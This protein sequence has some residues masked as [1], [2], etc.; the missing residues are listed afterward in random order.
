MMVVPC[1]VFFLVFAYIPMT[2][3]IVAF[4]NYSFTKG[5]FRSPWASNYGFKYFIDFFGYYDCG[6]IIRNTF[7]SGFFKAILPFP[8]PILFALL[9]NEVGGNKFKRTVQTISYLP[10]FIS[11]VIVSVMLFRILAPEDGIVNQ[12]IGAAGGRTDTFFMMED[13]YF[14]PILFLSLLWKNIGWSS[15][16]Y[17]AAISGIDPELYEAAKI[18]GAKKLRQIWHITLAGLKPTMGILFILAL[19]GIVS[20]GFEQNF[21]LRTPGNMHLADILDTFVLKQGFERGE[22]SYATAI[23]MMQ[24]LTGL[25]MVITA[26]K[27]SRRFLEVSIW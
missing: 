3:L 7:A 9:M 27:L 20:T 14:Y 4:K 25:I 10:Y 12:L 15:I 11:W 24:G 6:T 16:I 1:V 8:F 17:L 21:L 19:G 13:K 26:N 5:I 2:G 22:Y 23:G 18:D